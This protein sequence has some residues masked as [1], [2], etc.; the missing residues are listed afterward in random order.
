LQAGTL[1]FETGCDLFAR[2][3]MNALVGNLAF[4]M[5]EK[6]VFFSKRFEASPFECVTSHV[7][8]TTFYL[9]FVL[10]FRW[11]TRH[12]VQAVMPTKID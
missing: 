10:G 12:H 4:P 7:S 3:A 2:R 9:A 11:P 5:F 6:K 1:L 8:Y